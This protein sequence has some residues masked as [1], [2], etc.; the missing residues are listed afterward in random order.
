MGIVNVTPDS[1]SDGGAYFE[2]QQA[3]DHGL[4]LAAEGA[5]ILDVGGESTRPNAQPVS[6]QEEVDRV[7][8]V[9]E[10]LKDSGLLLS[11][12]TRHAETM[13]AAVKAG[14]GMINDVTAL[15]G[16]PGSVEAAA[17]SGAYICLM[18]MQ[19]QPQT[20][21]DDP[22]YDDVIADITAYLRGRIDACRAAG[23]DQSRLLVDPG[24]GFGK[25]LAHN[26]TIL[27]HLEAFEALG[28][29]VL[30]GL[31][32]K[33]FIEKLCPDTPASERLPGSLAGA[34]WGVQRGA[35]VLRVHDVAATRQALSVWQ[36][37]REIP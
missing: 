33:S 34:L 5:D 7:L 3:I 32:R 1:F 20:M 17:K 26:L 36:S 28:V 14:A 18:H 23:I 16:E 37:I 27:R 15:E 9:I 12:D 19:G 2:P 25:T 24:I 22:H 13:R 21:Q 6:P 31:S 4:Q 29:P 30:L 10:G 11:I 8:P 35:A